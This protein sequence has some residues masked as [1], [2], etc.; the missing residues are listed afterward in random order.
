VA[1]SGIAEYRHGYT[2]QPNARRSTHRSTLSGKLQKYNTPLR[3]DALEGGKE[4]FAG[5]ATKWTQGP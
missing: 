4:A 3:C 5:D 2:N 1:N